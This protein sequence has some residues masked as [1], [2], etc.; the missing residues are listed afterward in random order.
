MNRETYLISY[1]HTKH[2]IP[3][4]TNSSVSVITMARLCQYWVLYRIIRCSLV[5]SDTQSTTAIPIRLARVWVSI[6]FALNWEHLDNNNRIQWHVLNW[7]HYCLVS[8]R[9]RSATELCAAK[10]TKVMAS[11]THIHNNKIK[12]NSMANRFTNCYVTCNWN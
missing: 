12:S 10:R 2:I 3:F 1:R 6:P 8:W 5:L 4:S 7:T 9:F 11:P